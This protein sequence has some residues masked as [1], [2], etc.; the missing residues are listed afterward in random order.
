MCHGHDSSVEYLLEL[1][2]IHEEYSDQKSKD[3]CRYKIPIEAVLQDGKATSPER[4]E[5]EPL[6]AN[7]S[8]SLEITT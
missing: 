7:P 3:D 4:E 8:I 6:P 5:I 2:H 1:W